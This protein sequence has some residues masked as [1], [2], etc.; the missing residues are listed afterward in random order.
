M[1]RN[2][3]SVAIPTDKLSELGPLPDDIRVHLDAGYDSQKT[4][5]ELAARSI[6]GEIADCEFGLGAVA[7]V[8]LWWLVRRTSLSA[9]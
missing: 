4:R 5:D 1:D 7:A 6:T 8:I 2:H 3:H 9:G